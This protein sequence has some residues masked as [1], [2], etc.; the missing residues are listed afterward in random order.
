MWYLA[1]V[2]PIVIYCQH[3]EYYCLDPFM[4]L[5]IVIRNVEA[6]E[7]HCANEECNKVII[8]CQR[9]SFWTLTAFKV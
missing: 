8:G 6:G 5:L 2:V 4:Q 1:G 9:N 7:R 3:M